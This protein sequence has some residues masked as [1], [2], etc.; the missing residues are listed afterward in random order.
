MNH[1]PAEDIMRN[2]S[3]TKN[4]KMRNNRIEA[5]FNHPTEFVMLRCFHKPCMAVKVV[6]FDSSTMPPGTAMIRSMCPKHHEQGGWGY[7]EYYTHDGRIIEYDPKAVA[8][9]V[10]CGRNLFPAPTALGWVKRT[11]NTGVCFDC[12][13]QLS[14][15]KIAHRKAEE[16]IEG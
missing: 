5:P 11:H 16:A 1:T 3:A 8:V 13:E 4:R 9:C 14:A 12:I 7:E 10:L 6:P 15:V 2:L